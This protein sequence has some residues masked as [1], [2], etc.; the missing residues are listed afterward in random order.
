LKNA[1]FSQLVQNAKVEE[2]LPHVKH[3]AHVRIHRLYHNLNTFHTSV[4]F[5]ATITATI[6]I[7]FTIAAVSCSF[8]VCQEFNSAT[9]LLALQ[10]ATT[11]SLYPPF[12]NSITGLV[13]DKPLE[14]GLSLLSFEAGLVEDNP[15]PLPFSLHTYMQFNGVGSH[16]TT[17]TKERRRK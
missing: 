4:F 2:H 9:T 14:A 11:A 6:T 13:E 7:P 15:L 16:R 1:L 8:I 10:W 17:M 12:V 3:P 5:I